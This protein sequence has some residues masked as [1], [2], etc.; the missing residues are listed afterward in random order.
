MIPVGAHVDAVA[1]VHTDSH[2]HHKD[3]DEASALELSDAN[4]EEHMRTERDED[5]EDWGFIE[6]DG[7]ERNEP[8]RSGSFAWRGRRSV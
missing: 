6:A 3:P 5:V 2:I 1:E 8:P 7:D 4:D